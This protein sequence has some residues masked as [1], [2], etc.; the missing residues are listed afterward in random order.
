VVLG[1]RDPGQRRFS[2]RATRRTD[3]RS[4]TA[5]AIVHGGGEQSDQPRRVWRRQWSTCEVL[6]ESIRVYRF[7][8][9]DRAP[10]RARAA[11]RPSWLGPG[12][13]RLCSRTHRDAHL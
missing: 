12:D 13:I 4:P 7:V 6:S 9:A 1:V 2:V 5:P 3:R 8:T 10:A 11:G